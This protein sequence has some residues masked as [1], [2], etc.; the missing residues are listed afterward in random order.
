MFMIDI[1]IAEGDQT[2]R[3]KIY[4]EQYNISRKK[5]RRT[6][7]KASNLYL[8]TGDQLDNLNEKKSLIRS[9]ITGKKITS[10]KT[11]VV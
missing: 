5:T 8:L 7:D 6:K 11:N 1:T 9:I 3:A 4:S 10:G 2:D